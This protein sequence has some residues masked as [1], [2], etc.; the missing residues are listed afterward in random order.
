[1]LLNKLPSN[2]FLM[3]KKKK[4]SLLVPKFFFLKSK[5]FYLI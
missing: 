4:K 3:W 5:L 1:M 2:V